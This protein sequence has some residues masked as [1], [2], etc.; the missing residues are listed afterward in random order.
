M[1]VRC[2]CPRRSWAAR[3]QALRKP[4]LELK[5]SKASVRDWSIESR[6]SLIPSSPAINAAMA[7][8]KTKSVR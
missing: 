3:K 8:S 1:A 4:A 6:V 2:F 5:T 7:G